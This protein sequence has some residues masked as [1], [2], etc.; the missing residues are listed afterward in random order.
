M[1]DKIGESS[2]QGSQPQLPKSRLQLRREERIRNDPHYFNPF[3]RLYIGPS[4]VTA[5]SA[6]SVATAI[7]LDVQIEKP[8]MI[9]IIGSTGTIAAAALA[10]QSLDSIAI[11]SQSAADEVPSIEA[12][13]IHGQ[14]S[15]DGPSGNNERRSSLKRLPSHQSLQTNSSSPVKR[16]RELSPIR[17]PGRSGNPSQSRAASSQRRLHR[18]SS[19]ASARSVGASVDGRDRRGSLQYEEDGHGILRNRTSRRQMSQ[20][21]VEPRIGHEHDTVKFNLQ[22]SKQRRQQSEGGTYSGLP[23]TEAGHSRNRVLPLLDTSVHEEDFSPTSSPTKQ[24]AISPSRLSRSE[25]GLLQPMSSHRSLGARFRSP[26]RKITPL[27]IRA[28]ASDRSIR[29]DTGPISPTAAS[30]APQERPSDPASMGQE[31][32]GTNEIPGDNPTITNDTQYNELNISS[33]IDELRERA[34]ERYRKAKLARQSRIPS[35]SLGQRM[36]EAGKRR[37]H[38]R[39]A[40][41]QSRLSY[42]STVGTLT[43]VGTRFTEGSFGAQGG[44]RAKL[45]RSFK[46]PSKAK[47]PSTPNLRTESRR[48]V[49]RSVASGAGGVVPGAIGTSAGGTKWVGQ[50]FEIGK[51]F[52]QTIEN[53]EELLLGGES[54]LDD[55]PEEELENAT[56]ANRKGQHD[57]QTSESSANM[58]SPDDVLFSFAKE[59]SNTVDGTDDAN[60]KRKSRKGASTDQELSKSTDATKA[61]ASNTPALIQSS[62]DSE[63]SDGLPVTPERDGNNRRSAGVDREDKHDSETMMNGDDGNDLERIRSNTS[64]QTVPQDREVQASW[65]IESRTG[66]SDVVSFMSAQS[67]LPASIQRSARSAGDNLN[68]FGTKAKRVFDGPL[69]DFR[70]KQVAAKQAREK[71]R[72]HELSRTMIREGSQGSEEINR[73]KTPTMDKDS[74]RQAV[75][76]SQKEIF[77]SPQPP[78][79]CE[80]KFPEATFELTRRTSLPGLALDGE[81]ND[82]A[83]DHEV[84]ARPTFTEEPEVEESPEQVGNRLQL[85]LPDFR[86]DTQK[87]SPVEI[88]SLPVDAETPAERT[89]EER[90]TSILNLKPS[91]NNGD[92]KEQKMVSFLGGPVPSAR[93]R[94]VT[95]S[96]VVSPSNGESTA[97]N[98]AGRIRP[99]VRMGNAAP[100]PPEEVLLRDSTP[101]ERTK[102][103][104]TLNE[105]DLITSRSIL[106]RDRILVKLMWTASEDV[107]KEFTERESRKYEL[108]ADPFREFMVVFRMGRLELWDDPSWTSRMIGK[109]DNLKLRYVAPLRKGHAFVSLYS[110]VDTIFCLSFVPAHHRGLFNLRRSGTHVWLFDGRTASNSADWMWDLWRELGGQ[111]PD[112]IDVHIPVLGFRVRIPIPDEIPNSQQNSAPKS[113]RASTK[114][115]V[116]TL[117]R[118]IDEIDEEEDSALLEGEGYKLINR[119]NVVKVV[120]Q[121]AHFVPQWA[122]LCARLEERGLHFGLAWR[123][124]STLSWV[125]HV[126]TMDMQRRDWAVLVGSILCDHKSPSTLEFRAATHYPQSV[127]TV[128]GDTLEEPPAI[129]GFLWRVK[130]VSGALTRLYITTQD[131]LI[132]VNRPSRAFPPERYIAIEPTQAQQP[133]KRSNSSAAELSVEYRR[134]TRRG[135]KGAQRADDTLATLGE[136][137]IEMIT[138]EAQTVEEL[139]AQTEAYRAFE[140]RRLFE[141]IANSDGYVDVRDIYSIY[142]LDGKGG[143]R[144]PSADGKND[145]KGTPKEEPAADEFEDIFHDIGG[146]EGYEQSPD[147]NALKQSRQFE[148]TMMNGRTVRFEAYSQSVCHEWVNQIYTLSRYWKR[149]EKVDA[150]EVMNACGHDP[151]L[152]HRTHRKNVETRPLEAEA[153][154]ERVAPILGNIWNWCILDA[155]R[156]ILRSGRLFTKKKPYAAFASRYCVLVSGRILTFKLMTS[157]RTAR[158]RQNA[159]LFHKRQDTVI[160]LRDSYVYSGKLTDHMLV[161]GRSDGA[162]ALS[163]FGGGTGGATTSST[164][165]TLPRIYADGLLSTDED[166]ECTFV[167]RYRPQRVNR[168]LNPHLHNEQDAFAQGDGDDDQTNGNENGITQKANASITTLRD[169]TVNVIAMRA[170]SRLERDLWVWAINAE[171][172]RVVRDDVAR[173]N[174]I[175]QHG[176]T[177]Y[178]YSHHHN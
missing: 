63:P 78:L 58:R 3:K 18:D 146:E 1:F 12:G 133:I 110:A 89:P 122:E 22:D 171:R 28:K 156:T 55:V 71:G 15:L 46:F 150:L 178:K 111:I 143:V 105:A 103:G 118:G 157:N 8:T 128:T 56:N 86:S 115:G 88:P 67:S 77:D 119:K 38:I 100:A 132:F 166:E 130:A 169:S 125:Q 154:S 120:S 152:I 76:M 142:C 81:Q 91:F 62:S 66:W 155:C 123:T 40:S 176:Q 174:Q 51:R 126:H 114:P 79:E 145:K 113:M 94:S 21:L 37:Q 164:R 168:S 104:K 90:M 84:A 165:H 17:I 49:R 13:S 167:V 26:D 43:S 159:G 4:P 61:D 74:K 29:T 44:F 6:A 19:F 129:E 137:V 85:P 47:N 41:R 107:P 147:R 24:R 144:R 36:P 52:R 82:A 140:K 124:H 162:G 158:A 72:A 138:T 65:D 16:F 131:G 127:R 54:A 177:P 53:Q 50:T 121:L 173:E 135:S 102:D 32:V 2:Q 116:K 42:L 48:H 39:D 117:F 149:R 9:G 93:K 64:L 99:I 106:K 97:T 30:A 69:S 148:L 33:P 87:R 14:S 160:H 175:R 161:N 83:S 108:H 70:A 10:R 57:R 153:G 136:K 75:K 27:S 5:K 172:E 35:S 20:S 112:A 92:K 101:D 141:Q 11:Q 34:R 139:D 95:M 98:L 68:E 170:R 109:A 45:V 73:S 134:R 7:A 151:A 80:E 23:H 60:R 59:A 25:D 163:N 96:E 31:S